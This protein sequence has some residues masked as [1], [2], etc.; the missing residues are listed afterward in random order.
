MTDLGTTSAAS[1]AAAIAPM[2][3]LTEAEARAR[4]EGGR[5]NLDR[6]R[7]RSDRDVIRGNLLTFFNVVLATL[8]AALL[9]VGEFSDG[10][11]VGGVVF[12]NVAVATIQELQATR[13]LRELRALTAPR[14]TVVRDGLERSIRAAEVVEGDLLHLEP[15]DQ[16]VADGPIVA[17]GA[18]IDESLLTGESDPVRRERG[19]ELRSGS[20]CVAGDCYYTA[21]RVGEQ[22][23]AVRLTA[24]SRQLIKRAS[25]LTH[26]FNRLLR[27]LL[28]TTGALAAVLFI[29]FNIDERGLAESL[30]ATTATVTTVVPA[31]LLLGMTIV[32]AVGAL[33]VSRSGAIVQDMQGVEALNYV[34]VI[35][36]DKTGT[37]TTNRLTLAAVDW[38]T[39]FPDALDGW[40]AAYAVATEGESKTADA[41][42]EEL[43]ARSN[44]AVRVAQVPF[45]SARRWSAATL[46]HASDRM[47]LVLGAPETLFAAAGAHDT[48]RLRQAYA[49]ATARGLRGVLLAR[50]EVFGATETV[51]WDLATS[52]SAPR[53]YRARWHRPYITV[54]SCGFT[55]LARYPEFDLSVQGLTHS[56][57]R[58]LLDWDTPPANRRIEEHR[59]TLQE[60]AGR[61]GLTLSAYA[62]TDTFH[63][64]TAETG[65]AL[66]TNHND[67]VQFER[68]HERKERTRVV[69]PASFPGTA[70]DW[71]ALDRY[72]GRFRV[73]RRRQIRYLAMQARIRIQRWQRRLSGAKR[74]RMP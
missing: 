12:A 17:E 47:T 2:R 63:E 73:R 36:L 19:V 68:L 55:L 48:S 57:A 35:G 37:L 39:E 4:L 11:F 38:L 10:L 51:E 45:S 3:G 60:F 9:A 42:A 32:T 34:D 16:V 23:Y 22:A 61:V 20:F 44:G 13:R 66:I 28:I 31:G 72:A 52:R 41:L 25:P 40:L 53:G 30:K 18:E 6:S 62:P 21:A 50:V 71:Q 8:I 74:E 5:S 64:F 65:P 1:P 58:Q 59:A 43:R 67:N 54:S 26:R 46:Q 69:G 70:I 56:T 24:E 29:Q 15:G 49:D 7:Q 27:M 33:R 14:A